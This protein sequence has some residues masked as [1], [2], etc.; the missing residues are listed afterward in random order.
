MQCR[1][2]IASEHLRD[3]LIGLRLVQADAQDSHTQGRR[4]RTCL[5]VGGGP[6]TGV[7][8]DGG[9]AAGGGHAEHDN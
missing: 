2:R 6:P 8:V 7:A 5:F 3:L 4:Q 1:R 9:G